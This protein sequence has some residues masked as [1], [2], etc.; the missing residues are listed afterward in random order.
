MVKFVEILSLL[1]GL[2]KVTHCHLTFFSYV[3]KDCQEMLING[4]KA[5]NEQILRELF[6]LEIVLEILKIPLAKTVE[7]DKLIWCDSQLEQFSIKFGYFKARTMLGCES[8]QLQ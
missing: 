6:Q 4:K 2:G 3:R 7:I 8:N 1:E 5:W